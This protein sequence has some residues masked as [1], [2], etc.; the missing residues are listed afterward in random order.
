M[1]I[2]V[3]KAWDTESSA[4]DEVI[5][6]G[7]REFLRKSAGYGIAAGVALYGADTLFGLSE[8]LAALPV[9]ERKAA[10]SGYAYPAPRNPIFTLDRPLTD[11]TVA[12][13]YNNFYEFSSRKNVY[14]YVDGFKTRPWTVKISGLV[15]KP[16][17]YDVE[18][19]IKKFGVEERLYRLRCVE[20]WAMA[21]PWTGFPMRKLLDMVE[22]ESSAKYVVFKTLYDRKVFRQQTIRFWLPWPYTEGLTMAEA[23]NELTLLATGIYGHE[24]PG[25]HGAPIRLVTPWKYGFKSIKSIVSIEFAEKQPPTFWNTLGPSEYAFTSNVD[26]EVPHPRWSQATE[27]ML[28]SKERRKTL[29]YN[30]YGEFVAGLYR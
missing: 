24:L 26:P 28:G 20:A 30:G 11:E 4:T 15:R 2:K 29:K 10:L 21:V 18:K 5:Y 17:V 25:Q 23:A 3:K 6:R 22:P 19:L 7:R 27:R 12:G 14:K 1:F 9:K 13:R 8:A 16:G